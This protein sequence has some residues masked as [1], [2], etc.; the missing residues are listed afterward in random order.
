MVLLDVSIVNVALPSIRSGLHAATSELQWVVSGYSLTFGLML[1]PAGR[2]GDMR[3]RRGVFI[4]ALGAFVIASAA[5]GAATGSTWLVVA[6]LVQGLAGGALTPQISAMIQELFA[7]EERGKAFGWFGSVVGISTAIGPLV[8]GLLIHAFG[9]AEGWRAVFYVN[10]PIGAVLIPFAWHLLGGLGGH[11][12]H[13]DFDPVGI[14]LLGA[15]AVVLLLPF[16]EDRMWGPQRWL[17]LLVAAALIA[18]FIWW[19][20][21]YDRSG[22]EPV[23]DLGLFARRSYAFGVS[24][25][26][27]YFC[28]FTP[29]FF[30]F[31]LFMQSGLGYSALLAGLS[32]TP[33]ALGS[34][35]MASFGGRRALRYGRAL[36][37]VGLTTVAVG[38]ALSAFAVHLVPGRDA[39]LATLAPLLLA[40]IGGGL[41]IAPNQTLTLSEVPVR[42][43]GTAGG[44]LQTAQRIG[45]SVG[46][47][48]VGSV[49]FA[50][51]ASGSRND[52]AGAYEKSVLLSVAFIVAALVVTLIDLVVE[53]RSP[54]REPEHER[55]GIVDRGIRPPT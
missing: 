1:V 21:R 39:P 41:V 11:A 24:M 23:V 33:F 30:V 10:V 6:R 38:V 17:L 8:G 18:A 14:L 47:A 4:G 27:L 29:I 40:G 22:R 25:I 28:A 5:C 13:H 31:T 26:L 19:E 55:A 51:V 54:R 16:V 3:G 48:A 42:Q 53:R 35:A 43:A 52:Y 7:G 34:A 49:F 12:S 44:L 45:A 20:R 9:D 2:F 46:I 32:I 15:S 36:I 37:A 50:S